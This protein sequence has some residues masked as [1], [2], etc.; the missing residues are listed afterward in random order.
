MRFLINTLASQHFVFLEK[1][2]PFLL[3]NASILTL[4]KKILINF[5]VKIVRF[6]IG[7]GKK[8]LGTTV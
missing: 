5:L 4:D 2:E 7:N 6:Q 8:R 3:G 1:N